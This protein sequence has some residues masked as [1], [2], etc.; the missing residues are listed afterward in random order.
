M[1]NPAIVAPDKDDAT[2]YRV[3]WIDDDGGVEVTL[4]SGINAR[5]RAVTYAQW[6][7]QRY[8]MWNT[9]IWTER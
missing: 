4:F 9:N 1:S 2:V 7:Y 3:E 5:N 8:E 6:G